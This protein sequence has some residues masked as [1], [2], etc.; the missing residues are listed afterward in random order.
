MSVGVRKRQ[1]TILARSYREISLT[2]RIVCQYI[3]SRVSVSVRPSNFFYPKNIQNLG[4]IGSSARVFI[5]L[6]LL[7]ALNASGEGRHGWAPTNC[8]N[9]YGGGDVCVYARARVCVCGRVRACVMCLQ[10]TIIIFDPS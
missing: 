8:A 5:P 9:L 4:E 1:V 7:P 2:V 6:I 3:L 10:Y